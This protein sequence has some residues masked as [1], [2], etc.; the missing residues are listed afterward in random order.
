MDQVSSLEMTVWYKPNSSTVS[1]TYMQEQRHLLEYSQTQWRLLLSLTHNHV[2]VTKTMFIFFLSTLEQAMSEHNIW[3]TSTTIQYQHTKFTYGNPIVYTQVQLCC[4]RTA[5]TQST[6]NLSVFLKA[7][8]HSP[9][10]TPST[11][12]YSSNVYIS[13]D[14]LKQEHSELNLF[15]FNIMHQLVIISM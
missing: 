4:E 6:I 11:I 8:Q 15:S 3:C 7:F 14:W 5:P 9:Q 13:K 10:P 12:F 1:C 2:S